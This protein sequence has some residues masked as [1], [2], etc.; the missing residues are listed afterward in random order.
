MFSFQKTRNLR[1][2]FKGKGRRFTDEQLLK[3]AN[4]V[5][6]STVRRR[7][8]GGGFDPNNPRFKAFFERRVRSAKAAKFLLT[9]GAAVIV[10]NSRAG[11]GGTVFVSG[12]SVAND[13]PKSIQ[14][15][16]RR[17]GNRLRAQNKAAESKMLPQMTMA[18]RKLQSYCP[19]D[20][21]WRKK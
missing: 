21:A 20:K 4:A 5:D 2:D 17:G 8:R 12:A 18:K 14:D 13:P 9:E 10:D 19:N 11:D 6:P 16:F 7:A 1:A 15:I 3:M